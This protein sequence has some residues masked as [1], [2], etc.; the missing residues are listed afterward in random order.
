MNKLFF[1]DTWLKIFKSFL[2]CTV[3]SFG[4]H[5]LF[6]GGFFIFLI[7]LFI[8]SSY[9]IILSNSSLIFN[10]PLYTDKQKIRT[11]CVGTGRYILGIKK[12]VFNNR[13]VNNIFAS[14]SITL[15]F[16]LSFFLYI[17]LDNSEEAN[18][19]FQTTFYI[20][21]SLIMGFSGVQGFFITPIKYLS[22]VFISPYTYHLKRKIFNDHVLYY[23]VDNKLL[24]Y[25]NNKLHC[26]KTPAWVDY[27]KVGDNKM[28]LVKNCFKS[29]Y[30]LENMSE[31]ELENFQLQHPHNIQQ[32]WY[33]NGIEIGKTN[34]IEDHL[35]MK[36]IIKTTDLVNNF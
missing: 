10:K 25:K 20:V 17:T 3:I 30:E 1:K 16:S 23:T 12:P 7:I 32:Y 21:I 8:L 19:L 27:F 6:N 28:I 34:N 4:L 33:L 15:A 36:K 2:I 14:L 35:A 11:F 9:K 18:S 24:I 22:F 13:I 26:D 29:W 31:D 5:Y